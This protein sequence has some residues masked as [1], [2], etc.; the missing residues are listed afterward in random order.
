MRRKR[1]HS[2][3]SFTLVELVISMAV[4]TILLAGLTS[5]VILAAQALPGKER[6]ADKLLQQARVL[7]QLVGELQYALFF[8]ERGTRAITFT[9]ADRNG[10]GSPERIRYAGRA[11]PVI[12]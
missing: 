10:D 6:L 11:R 8:A 1:R 7:D 3:R 12:R 2:F 4:A 5:A 9:V